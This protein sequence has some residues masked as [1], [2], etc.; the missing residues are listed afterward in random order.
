[1][2]L[3]HQK[4]RLL[5]TQNNNNAYINNSISKTQ[6]GIYSQGLNIGS[7]NSGTVINQNLIN[8]VAPNNTSRG[9][10]IVGF[11]DNISISGN[12]ISEIALTSSPDVFGIT[13]GSTAISTS[14]FNGDEITNATITKNNIGNI[15]NTGTFSACGIFISAAISGTNTISNNMITGV[16]ANGIAGDFSVGLLVGGGAGSVTKI[17]NNTITMTNTFTNPGASDKSYALAIG[18]LNA[19]VDVRNN[20]FYNTQNNGSGNNYAVGYG[21]TPHTN[22][23]SNNNEYYVGSGAN[24]MIGGT[25]ALNTSIVNQPTI[26]NLQAATLK[27]G[28]ALNITPGF[29][30]TSDMHLLTTDINNLCL[31]GAGVALSGIT[32][33]I[34]CQVRGT[35]PDIGA[36]EFTPNVL[37]VT[38]PTN[39]CPGRNI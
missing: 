8:T 38:N 33:H 16:S 30:S 29:V 26:A 3:Q 12:S 34:D 10:I 20:I 32:D 13:T 11:E 2:V 28:A 4:S 22:L 31:N 15:R 27:D 19:V 23:T 21:Y 37:T 24:F 18:G 35:L 36:D 9:G 1:M 7:K 17:Y 25:F 5:G 14:T 6:Y 39:L